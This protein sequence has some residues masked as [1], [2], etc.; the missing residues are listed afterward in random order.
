[1]STPLAGDVPPPEIKALDPVVVNR[2]AAGEVI[3]RPASALKELL[4]NSIDA[5]AT[6]IT[7]SAREGGLKMLQI[8][9]NGH[10]IR[11]A[12]L[13]IVCK[14]FTTSKLRAFDDLKAIGTYGFRGEALA[15]I[16][17]VAH[18]QITSKTKGQ[19]CA[20]RARYIDG[21]LAP[22][23]PGAEPRAEKVAGVVGT[24]ILVE[25]LFYNVKTRRAALT[26][27]SAE[28]KLILDVVSKY[29]IHSGGKGRGITCKKLGKSRSS[30]ADVHTRPSASVLDNIRSVY[31]RKL[32]QELIP[33]KV[34]LD[35]TQK[36]ARGESGGGKRAGDF[37]EEEEEEEEDAASKMKFEASGYVSNANWS[38]RRFEFVLFINHRLVDCALLKR[39]LAA[40]YTEYLP[41]GRSPFVYMSIEIA[42][43]LVDVNVHP[44][45]R[46][47]LFLHQE[48]LVD[49]ISEALQEV[50]LGANQSRTFY[51][52]AVFKPEAASVGKAPHGASTSKGPPSV[53]SVPAQYDP[54][55]NDAV[56]AVGGNEVGQPNEP[57]K[58]VNLLSFSRRQRPSSAASSSSSSS[59]KRTGS[60]SRPT[61]SGYVEVETGPLAKKKKS[62][63]TKGG[64]A[65]AEASYAH[66]LT[67][68][69]ARANTMDM[70]LSR[71]KPAR[72]SSVA[73]A[74][75]GAGQ[76]KPGAESGVV[77]AAAQES[78]AGQEKCQNNSQSN[79]YG[80]EANKGINEV[81]DE[82]C[83]NQRKRSRVATEK[84]TAT[85]NKKPKSS[86]LGYDACLELTEG[87][88]AAEST[89]A[90]A[91][92]V[93]ELIDERSVSDLKRVESTLRK[94]I[95]LTENSGSGVSSEGA[96]RMTLQYV[97]GLL[98]DGIST[99]V[100]ASD[101]DVGSD[102]EEDVIPESQMPPSPVKASQLSDDEEDIIFD[103]VDVQSAS[104]SSTPSSSHRRNENEAHARG[105][106]VPRKY[107]RANCRAPESDPGLLTSVQDFRTGL[108]F[109]V[110][111]KLKALLKGH[112]FIG[113]VDAK[114][115]LVQ[116]NTTVHVV[117]H[118]VLAK[119]FFYQQV[120]FNMGTFYAL[121]IETPL[122]ITDLFKAA[123]SV[124]GN[125]THKLLPA[126][127][128][129]AEESLSS[130]L[131]DANRR[132]MLNDYFSIDIN[133]QGCLQ[134]V[135]DILPGYLPLPAAL[136]VLIFELCSSVDWTREQQCFE[137]VAW[138]LGRAFGMLPRPTNPDKPK[139]QRNAQATDPE[140]HGSVLVSN[141]KET[142][143][144][145]ELRHVLQ[146][147]IF[148]SFKLQ[149]T[150][151][152]PADFIDDRVIV[153][154]AS[155]DNL[156][157]V[158]ERC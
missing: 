101:K 115:S 106:D 96:R 73:R 142:D 44:T 82:A 131:G 5:G 95:D 137:D 110:S 43:H 132:A 61:S 151:Y 84:A 129:R 37:V 97:L 154:V 8:A 155:L 107:P 48:L 111:S 11:A 141:G 30:T 83:A 85:S 133:N 21:E 158:F 1:M 60:S 118:E 91:A 149:S 51:T 6:S 56:D 18:V 26:R 68:T 99:L 58:V 65:H 67:R 143:L 117:S 81:L 98:Q 27:P 59:S 45:K 55:P 153:Q 34:S 136:P 24:Q 66:H 16:T 3:H 113:V 31:G 145:V 69:D 14:R 104:S 140:N 127:V 40:V 75:R 122:R 152:P 2:I 28:Y 42:P 150:F 74:A 86:S 33:F 23:R 53:T 109:N 17:H 22:M 121:E 157:K 36:E 123:T 79:K 125:V 38:Q 128:Q 12:D 76:D 103:D 39:A 35:E 62:S 102:D 139:A 94:L 124:H 89:A 120:L 87:I 126:E 144:L 134:K 49:T 72:N 47:V 4:E 108:R 15:S 92:E 52:Q 88:L 100:R 148:P 50:L 19:S 138:A 116:Y 135:P 93:R 119:E 25:D 57:E 80:A 71:K 130:L 13:P 46:E 7:V 10:G 77:S 105:R 156:Y 146:N 64:N 114:S 70:Y 112:V 20:Y 54:S 90:M 147:V 63:K 9:D 41:H 78:G 32:T 29:A